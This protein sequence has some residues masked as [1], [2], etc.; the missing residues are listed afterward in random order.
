MPDLRS[1]QD[2]TIISFIKSS[3][4]KEI[5]NTCIKNETIKLEEKITKLESELIQLKESNIELIYLLTS[6]EHKN[7]EK[8]HSEEI[9]KNVTAKKTFKEAVTGNKVATNQ[10]RITRKNI[11]EN[12]VEDRT[13]RNQIVNQPSSSHDITNGHSNGNIE[14][15]NTETKEQ[16]NEKEGKWEFPKHKYRR[17]NTIIYGK[18]N[19][20]STFKG[21]VRYVN[22]HVFRCPLEMSTSDIIAYLNSKNIPDVK[23]ETMKSKN[24]EIYT[25]FKVAVP[26]NHIEAFENP[27]IW[28][29]YVGIDR[30]RNRFLLQKPLPQDHPK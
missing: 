5:I 19:D 10:Q 30:Y 26:V 27:N 24:P 17:R 20:D 13:L 1:K 25:S 4:F 12:K 15:N 7:M 2:G 29:E 18:G 6:N 8:S 9:Q 11:E 28:P 23:C 14:K 3:E 21:V 22:Y 16:K